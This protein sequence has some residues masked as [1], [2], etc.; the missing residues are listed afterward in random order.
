MMARNSVIR[1]GSDTT[2]ASRSKG[3]EALK[4]VC[5]GACHV[6]RKARADSPFVS[7]VS[8]PARI[9]SGFGG[10][11]RNVAE[12]LCRLGVAVELVSRVAGDADGQAVLGYLRDLPIGLESVSLSAAAP[13]AFHLI[14]L[15]P[16]G[17]MLVGVADMRIYDEI[18]PALLGRLPSEFWQADAVFADCNLPAESLSYI[19]GKL[20]ASCALA[21]NGVSPAKAVRARAVLSSIDFLFVNRAEAAA[22]ANGD[23]ADAGPEAIAAI[24]LAGGAGE[25]VLTLGA[26]GMLVAT[27]ERCLCLDSLPGPPQDVTGAGDALAAAFLAARL[28]GLD[29]ET[30]GRRALA[31]ARLTLDCPESVSPELSSERLEQMTSWQTTP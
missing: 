3:R 11:A 22:L 29:P 31:A 5:L 15:E 6:D 14:A 27:A 8:N 10:V 2:R 18:V 1:E 30:A 7:A 16:D 13:T 28:R 17:E 4:V 24:L 21:V 12:N 25:V 19:A 26:E 9:E 20:G 23:A